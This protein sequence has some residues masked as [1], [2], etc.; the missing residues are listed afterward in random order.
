MEEVDM[1]YV[2]LVPMAIFS[3]ALQ[4]QTPDATAAV[5]ARAVVGSSVSAE[6]TKG[7]DTKKAKIGDEVDAKTTTAAKL[8]D[9]R[10]LPKGTKLVGKVTDVRAKSKEDKTSHLAF[11]LDHAVLRDGQEVPVRA[12]VTSMTGAAA[13]MDAG[14]MMPSG[15][16]A[17]GGAPGGGATQAGGERSPTNSTPAPQSTVPSAMDGMSGAGQNVAAATISSSQPQVPVANMPGVV[18]SAANSAGSSGSLDAKDKNIALD[19]GTKM[20][21]SLAAE[22][23]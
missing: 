13:A 23:Q 22:G 3:F 7:I 5:G 15:G 14:A 17:G 16:G 6:L 2:L 18:L 19:S 1:R 9:G 20:T 4:A 21:L 10:E 8:P 11:S 12:A